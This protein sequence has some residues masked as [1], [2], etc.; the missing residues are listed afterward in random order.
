VLV[1]NTLIFVCR[2]HIVIVLISVPEGLGLFIHVSVSVLDT[3]TVYS[4]LDLP[5][6][7]SVPKIP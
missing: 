4:D 5:Y 6:S 7:S 1:R 3:Q 2:T